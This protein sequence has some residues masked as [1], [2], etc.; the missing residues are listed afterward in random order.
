MINST[1]RQVDLRLNEIEQRLVE[2]DSSQEEFSL[3]EE[4]KNQESFIWSSKVWPTFLLILAVF[5]KTLVKFCRSNSDYDSKLNSRYL[6][7]YK[8]LLH[9]SIFFF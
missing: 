8:E 3:E 1:N 5:G 4:E 9:I 6:V 7:V 2:G